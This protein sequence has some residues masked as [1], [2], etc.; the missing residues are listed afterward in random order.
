MNLPD[1]SLS[2]DRVPVYEPKNLAPSERDVLVE[3]IAALD[4]PA[5]LESAILAIPG[6]LGTG[7]FLGMVDA[8]VIQDGDAV[9]VRRR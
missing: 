7:L 5:E 6:V 8:V 3:E 1:Y 4:A 2:A 9:E